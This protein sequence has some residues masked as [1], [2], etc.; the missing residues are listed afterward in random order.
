MDKDYV[1]YKEGYPH[2]EDALK[3]GARLH[4]FLSG[5]GLRVVTIKKG[6]EELSYAE[7]P[8]FP[9]ALAYCDDDFGQ[10]YEQLYLGE[11]PKH[12]H[13]LTGAYPYPFD[14]FDV[15]L[16]QGRTFDVFYCERWK[17]FI[18]TIPAPSILHRNNEILW[19]SSSGLLSAIVTCLLSFQ[20]EDK[21][22]FEKKI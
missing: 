2:I 18:C 12:S 20:F 3:K 15:H 11:N 13:Y 14:A 7:H 16:K 6:D 8:Y 1:N 10:D 4:A 5:G 17:Q 19:G 9:G 22:E 21:E